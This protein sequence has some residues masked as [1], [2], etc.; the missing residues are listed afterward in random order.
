MGGRK[1]LISNQNTSKAIKIAWHW[2]KN[3][4]TDKRNEISSQEISSHQYI[5]L[6]FDKASEN[7]CW[8]KENTFN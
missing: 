2:H 1:Y 5:Q 6:I 8:R 4:P 3:G 7:I